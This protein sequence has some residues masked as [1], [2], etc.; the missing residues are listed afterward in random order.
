M[1]LRAFEHWLPLAA[2]DPETG[3][4]RPEE[5]DRRR[6]PPGGGCRLPPQCLPNSSAVN[7]AHL[8]DGKNEHRLD[9]A[10]EGGDSHAPCTCFSGDSGFRA[11]PYSGRTLGSG[12]EIRAAPEGDQ[13][14]GLGR[15]GSWPGPRLVGAACWVRV[16]AANGLGL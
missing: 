16:E 1:F 7:A 5:A 6:A 13:G 3:R 15:A 2:E 10:L 12:G 9:K 11:A 14:E 8:K 4:R